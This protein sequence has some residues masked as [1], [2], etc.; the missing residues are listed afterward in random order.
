MKKFI[1]AA[2][3]FGIAAFVVF[4]FLNS[5]AG[6][7]FLQ[8]VKYR[9]YYSWRDGD[10]PFPKDQF[11][12]GFNTDR[13]RKDI[14]IGKSRKELISKL[15]LLVPVDPSFKNLDSHIQGKKVSADH[16]MQ[17][18]SSDWLLEFDDSDKCIYFNL[19]KG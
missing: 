4:Y 16:F 5:S 19:V 8:R 14:F 3:L 15:P 2:P 10:G 12:I 11:I 9:D 1:F 18:W 13:H 17:I 6:F 7:D